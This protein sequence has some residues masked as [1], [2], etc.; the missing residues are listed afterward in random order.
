MSTLNVD[1]V[2]P[3]TGT[4]LEIGSSGDTITVPSGATFAVSG[5]MNASSITAG[6]VATARLGTGTASSSTVL[7]GDQTYKTEPGG[8]WTLIKT[9]TAS[10]SSEIE[11]ADGVASVVFDSTYK[12]YCIIAQSVVSAS[13]NV[14]FNLYTSNDAGSSYET[15]YDAT[16]CRSISSGTSI[17]ITNSTSVIGHSGSYGSAAGKCGSLIVW[18]PS[19][20]DTGTYHTVYGEA[21]VSDDNGNVRR[22]MWGG[23]HE[24]AEAFN[25]IKFE[26]SSGNVASGTFSLYGIT[27]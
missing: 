15:S 23:F 22:A 3:S 20:S 27:T 5:T 11:F 8:A 1:K 14:E 26:F 10:S 18:I 12:M 16:D 24:T 9:V 25:A 19:P 6:T 13:N 7:Y 4:A 2:D 17:N 21:I